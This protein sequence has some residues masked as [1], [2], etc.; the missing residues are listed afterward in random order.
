M[1][2]RVTKSLLRR[3]AMLG[4]ATGL[5]TSVGVGLLVA[6][7]S[8][9]LGRSAA[10]AAVCA[11]LVLDKL[12]STGSRLEPPALGGRML[13]AALGA[14]ALARGE[15]RPPFGPA[16]VSAAAALGAAKAGHDARVA[17]ARRLP[18]RVVAIAEDA[19][20]FA[21]AIGAGA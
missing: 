5:R 10:A 9:V 13:V 16:V 7:R 18:D 19:L 1:A 11:E 2:T 8:G 3:T 21:F 6:R 15:R 17:L 12:P 14:A 20:A 4:A